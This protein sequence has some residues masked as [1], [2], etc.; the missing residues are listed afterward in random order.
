MKSQR[1]A[2]PAAPRKGADNAIHGRPKPA[3]ESRQ[4]RRD[5]DSDAGAVT[6]RNSRGRR[7]DPAGVVSGRSPES[8]LHGR[9]PRAVTQAA[10]GRRLRHA[11]QLLADISAAAGVLRGLVEFSSDCGDRPAILSA[12]VHSVDEQVAIMLAVREEIAARLGIDK[13]E[14]QAT[15][16]S[17]RWRSRQEAAGTD[18][19]GTERQRSRKK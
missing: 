15:I 4:T 8:A 2:K 7:A 12:I 5:Q 11:D 16:C 6:G 3:G 14:C 13:H 19:G 9:V 17:S 1:K 10:D 18:A